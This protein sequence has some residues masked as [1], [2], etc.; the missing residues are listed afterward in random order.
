MNV[1]NH[2]DIERIDNLITRILNTAR[3]KVEG[4]KRN[5]PFS[6]EKESQRA[7]KLYW[8]AYIR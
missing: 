1:L 6:K 8:K 3:K 4:I 7:T 2:E 5:I